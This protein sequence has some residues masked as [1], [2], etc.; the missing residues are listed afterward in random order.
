SSKIT[1]RIHWESAS[2]LR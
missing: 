1:H 2:L